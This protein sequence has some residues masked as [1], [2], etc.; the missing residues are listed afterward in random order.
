MKKY[1]IWNNVTDEIEAEDLTLEQAQKEVEG[2]V[3]NHSDVSRDDLEIR[4]MEETT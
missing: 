1:Y 4:E 3:E 2:A